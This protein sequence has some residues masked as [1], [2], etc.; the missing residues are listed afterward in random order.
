MTKELCNVRL[1]HM[2]QTLL[3]T[4]EAC[5]VLG[6]TSRSTLSRYVATGRLKPAMKMPGSTGA[7]LFNR[8][9]VE[10]LKAKQEKAA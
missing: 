2:T 8:A 3:T 6:L 9:D 1:L 10:K 7:F 5:E 4:S